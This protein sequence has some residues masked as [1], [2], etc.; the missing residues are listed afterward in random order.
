[1][2]VNYNKAKIKELIENIIINYIYKILMKEIHLIT[3]NLL[4]AEKEYCLVKATL[5]FL[6]LLC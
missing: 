5:S 2:I 6:F 3:K 1:L 4:N